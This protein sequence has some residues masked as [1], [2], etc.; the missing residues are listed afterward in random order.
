MKETK[1]EYEKRMQKDYDSIMSVFGEA[2]QETK[3]SFKKA[4]ESTR[5]VK[6]KDIINKEEC[7]RCHG[8]GSPIGDMMREDGDCKRCDGTGKEPEKVKVREIID[9]DD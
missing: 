1:E 4:F 8:S 2:M 5:K 7:K 9:K 3:G 6:V